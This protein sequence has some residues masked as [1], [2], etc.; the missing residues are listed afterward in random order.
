MKKFFLKLIFIIMLVLLFISSFIFIVDPANIF[1][2]KYSII[3]K[4]ILSNNIEMKNN[5][6]ER[7]LKK[8][9]I[10]NLNIKNEL[11]ILGSSRVMLLGDEHFDKNIFNAGVSGAGLEDQLALLNIYLKEV[12][13][14]EEVM[15]GIDPWTFN[16]NSDT[17]WNFIGEDYKEF[18]SKKLGMEDREGIK[19]NQKFYKLLEFMYLK[20]SIKFFLRNGLNKKFYTLISD[21][22]KYESKGNVYLRG[23]MK[24]IYSK[25]YREL[26]DGSNWKGNIGYQL[27]NYEKL[28][29]RLKSEFINTIIFLKS[30]NIIVK[31]F[32]PCYNPTL[33]EYQEKENVHYNNMIRNVENF[34]I[35][36]AKIRKV[37]VIGSYFSD[38]LKT[39]DFY[40]GIHLKEEKFK[41]IF[42]D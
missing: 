30:K 8:E 15:F 19:R 34:I 10:K 25:N 20:D 41:N 31:I 38:E 22:E 5:I 6:D 27:C 3:A 12:G 26:N 7:I 11:L 13:Y 35:Q 16:L 21:E 14:P 18:K 23:S 33:I 28:D 39:N 29:S 40:D 1:S 42:I 4:E 9:V 17:R 36:E 37:E 2:N 24:L 32:L